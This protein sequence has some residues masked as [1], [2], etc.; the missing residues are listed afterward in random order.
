M[1]AICLP[2]EPRRRATEALRMRIR[3]TPGGLL[4]MSGRLRNMFK[5]R[6][7]ICSKAGS[8]LWL[9]YPGP[10]QPVANDFSEFYSTETMSWLY[11]K[12]GTGGSGSTFMALNCAVEFIRR[13]F[14]GNVY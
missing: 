13:G 2:T 6:R 11:D 5:A 14:P 8:T 4:D 1:W 12:C 7:G 9:L 3:L 10:V